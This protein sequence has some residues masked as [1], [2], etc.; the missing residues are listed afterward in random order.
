MPDGPSTPSPLVY[1][2]IRKPGS[3]LSFAPT[4]LCSTPAFLPAPVYGQVPALAG[5]DRGILDLLAL[6]RAGR[7]SVIELKA[8]GRPQSPHPGS[9]LLDSCRP[10]RRPRP[11]FLS[12]LLPRSRGQS[13]CR[14]ACSWLLRRWSSIPRR[15]TILSFF[16]HRTR[17]SGANRPWR[18]MAGRT[19][20]CGCAP[21]APPGR[22]GFAGLLNMSIRF[23]EQV[24]TAISR[25][26][27]NPGAPGCRTPHPRSH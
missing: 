8:T 12:W 24:R 11:L 13:R 23:L 2:Q 20:G 25:L 10:P 17:D 15:R 4:S 18:R 5:H 21:V 3:N 22:S 16:S 1:A 19:Q 26:N 9:R 6:H 27:P 7:L 14:P